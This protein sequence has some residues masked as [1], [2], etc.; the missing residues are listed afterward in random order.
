[1]KANST[2]RK[3]FDAVD[4]LT[5]DTSS[6]MPV[7]TMKGGVTMLD[8]DSIKPFHNHP[9]HLYEGDRLDD[10][11][12]SIMHIHFLMVMLWMQQDSFSELI[13][14]KQFGTRDG[15]LLMKKSWLNFLMRKQHLAAVRF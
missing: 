10:M 3:I 7:K 12:E 13:V 14:A 8:I 15:Q 11:V 2:K 6:Q 4:L 1:M 9:F 5:E